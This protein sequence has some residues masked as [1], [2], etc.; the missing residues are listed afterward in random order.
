LDNFYESLQ[1]DIILL[2]TGYRILEDAIDRMQSTYT[3]LV[4]ALEKSA[5]HCI[6]SNG[7]FK[8]KFWWD[9]SM[10]IVKNNYMD[11]FKI[12]CA[13]GKPDTGPQLHKKKN[14]KGVLKKIKI[15][16]IFRSQMS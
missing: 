16:K 2:R 11:S 10:N 4:K 9:D 12:W 8:A 3:L 7:K 1:L 13:A 15:W 6:P 5:D 14:D